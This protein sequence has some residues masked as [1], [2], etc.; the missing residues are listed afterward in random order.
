MWI[1]KWKSPSS[2]E[3]NRPS[4]R[5]LTCEVISRRRD[6]A[7]GSSL[8]MDDMCCVIKRGLN[9]FVVP[10]GSENELSKLVQI[11]PC[12]DGEYTARSLANM[13]LSLWG[14]LGLFRSAR[15]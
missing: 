6:A 3:S 15:L 9:Q 4:R 1:K 10:S 13:E 14:V 2:D 12:E 7:A 5:P 11:W 8:T